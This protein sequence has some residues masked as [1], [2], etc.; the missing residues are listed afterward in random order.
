VGPS[1]QGEAN[2]IVD[3]GGTKVIGVLASEGKVIDRARLVSAGVREPTVLVEK[4]V[5]AVLELAGRHEVGVG[6]SL[7]AVPGTIDRAS[8]VVHSAANLPFRNFPL[9]SWFSRGL[10]GVEVLLEDDAN[11][12][13]LG[14][15]ALGSGQG[16]KDVLYITL[17]TGIGMGAVVD[18]RLV[19]GAHGLAGEL[20]HVAVVPGGRLCGCG[21]RGCLEAYAS[22][23]AIA[24]RG[25]E[26]LD[27]GGGAGLR[28]VTVPGT[29]VTA[30][31]VIAGAENGDG[32]CSAIVDEAVE[33]ISGAI[34]MLQR[35]IDPEVVVLGGGLMSSDFFAQL[36]LERARRQGGFGAPPEVR[37]AA[38]GEDSVIVGGMQVLAGDLEAYHGGQ[39]R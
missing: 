36:L 24:A 15:A 35:V 12:G 14:E 7:V 10:G 34:A 1:G 38:L 23:R 17:S 32:D 28:S 19:L 18:G 11:C 25:M 9:T 13:A 27:G 31:D 6:R 16:S 20:G 30:A 21:S 8:G 5:N 22:G 2:V 26:V 39:G 33:L 4:V 37:P 29:S 3:I